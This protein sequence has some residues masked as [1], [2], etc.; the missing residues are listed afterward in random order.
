MAE[1]QR[2][3]QCR[4]EN[5]PGQRFC[6]SCGAHLALI[7]L[8]CGETSP[9]EFKFCGKCGTELK[10]G[11]VAEGSGEER[12]VVTVLFA[13]LVGFTA[14]AEQLDPEDVRSLLSSYYGR[15]RVEVESFGGTVE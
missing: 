12:R 15:L 10:A 14:R 2:C 5:E 9:L 13:D 6:G 7:C 3:P 1:R 4:V 8:V 11:G